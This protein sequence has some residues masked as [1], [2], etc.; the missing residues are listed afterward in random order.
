LLFFLRYILGVAGK[1]YIGIDHGERRIGLAKSDPTGLIATP[2]KTISFRSMDEA[3]RMIKN[4]IETVGASGVV[5]GYP[6]SLSGGDKGERCRRV[7]QFVARLKKQYSGPVWTVDERLSSAEVKRV[8][9]QHGKKTGRQ[10]GII[11][12]MAAAVILQRFLDEKVPK[13]ED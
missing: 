3:I 10:K 4:E 8:I 5:V 12:R 6:L 7:D 9:H 13:A 11:D 2:Y 1:V